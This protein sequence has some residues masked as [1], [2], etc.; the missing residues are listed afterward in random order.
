MEEQLAEIKSGVSSIKKRQKDFETTLRELIDA[1]KI[2]AAK[3]DEIILSNTRVEKKINNNNEE[4]VNSFTT[5]HAKLSSQISET[6]IKTDIINSSLGS[7]G[8]P[9]QQSSSSTQAPKVNSVGI[10]LSG[11]I[12]EFF[13]RAWVNPKFRAEMLK[14]DSDILTQAYVDGVFATNKAAVEATKGGE[15]PRE[16]R[17]ARFLYGGLSDKSKD[18][19]KAWKASLSNEAS[20]IKDKNNT[21]HLDESDDEKT[22]SKQDE[23]PED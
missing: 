12:T 13:K 10:D 8:L 11:S 19:L 17:L 9:R 15:E 7:G 14:P 5:M 2:I 6:S 4:V 3:S 22:E 23:I 21:E 16:R 18:A 1:V 20:K